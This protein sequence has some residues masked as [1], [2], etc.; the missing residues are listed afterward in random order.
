[1]SVLVAILIRRGFSC[2]VRLL[3]F[4]S[5]IIFSLIP[6]KYIHA[7]KIPSEKPKLI[8]GI[9][10]DQMK[11]DY[12]NVFWD[13]LGED[14]LKKITT[15]GSFCKNA[16]YNYL[17]TQASVGQA[18]IATG[19]TPTYHGIISDYWYDRLKDEVVFCTDD[20]ECTT[21]EGSFEAGMMSPNK[22]LATTVSDEL[23]L[24]NHFKS[25]VYGISLNPNAAILSS[26]HNADAAFWYDEKSGK[27]ITS[28][29]YLDSLPGWMRD[30]NGKMLP[31]IYLNRIWEPV[32][33]VTQI[34]EIDTSE[35][36]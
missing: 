10:V 24:S 21:V 15:E 4:C 11:Y 23:K 18:T 12:I 31:D 17:F 25:K 1:M 19:T 9:V 30:F 16:R 29:Y 20:E 6:S 7:Q 27:W 34:V 22:L 14:G 8:I 33:E 3:I 28:S 36:S 5:I 13:N 26:G 32:T 2:I 35:P